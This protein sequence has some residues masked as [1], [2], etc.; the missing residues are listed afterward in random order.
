MNIGCGLL[1]FL[2]LSLEG[3]N[4]FLS[5]WL[6]IRKIYLILLDNHWSLCVKITVK[7]LTDKSC[8][9]VS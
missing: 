4:T 3:K 7:I 6:I 2:K 9:S 8:V 1:F 5:H